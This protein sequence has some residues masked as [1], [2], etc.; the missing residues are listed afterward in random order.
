MN[1][2]TMLAE[3]GKHLDEETPAALPRQRQ[4]LVEA[5]RGR[6]RRAGGIPRLRLVL[7]AG[8]VTGVAAAGLVVAGTGSDQPHLTP[9]TVQLDSAF[10]EKAAQVVS[11]QPYTAPK[12]R[13]WIYLK[14]AE[15]GVGTPGGKVFSQYWYRFDGRQEAV[16]EGGKVVVDNKKTGGR[17]DDGTPQGASTLLQ[18]LP[19]DP[20]ALL[21][22]LSNKVGAEPNGGANPGRDGLLFANIVQLIRNATPAGVPP[23]TMAALYRAIATLH[24]VHVDKNVVDGL[25]RHV[26]GLTHIAP[27]IDSSVLINPATYRILGWQNV[28]NGSS[29]PNPMEDKMPKNKRFNTKLPKGTITYG[30]V[31]VD[32]AVVDHAGQR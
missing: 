18:S 13:Q 8:V 19:T 15:Y 11:T 1:E 12:P 16:I 26:I 27:N 30:F 3:L 10:L 6:R 20:Q 22:A 28:W 7:A 23:K 9:S 25:G 2:L 31:T 24:G 4:R 17:N 5:T 21:T 14:V 29:T 32:T